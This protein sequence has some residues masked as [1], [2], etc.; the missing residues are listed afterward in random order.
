LRDVDKREI[1][2]LITV[3]EKPW[4]AVEVK[5]NDTNPSKHLKYFGERL[6]IPY[7]YQVVKKKD[8]DQYVDGVRIVSADRFL[9]GLV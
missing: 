4:F 2:F 5:Q 3:N 8:I 9:S 7:L 6:C 1:D